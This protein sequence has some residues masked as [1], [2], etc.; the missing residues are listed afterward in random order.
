[1]TGIERFVEVMDAPVTIQDKENAVT[2][3]NVRGDVTLENVTFRYNEGRPYSLCKA[4]RLIYVTTS[5]G[6]I[7]EYDLGF[8][9][10]ETMARGFFGIEKVMSVKAECLDIIGAD[11]EGIL[12]EARKAAESA[13][14]NF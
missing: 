2:L 8:R 9:Y 13:V 3:E 4:K 7:G 12:A 6:P 5:G 1:M 11:V 10:V 14:K